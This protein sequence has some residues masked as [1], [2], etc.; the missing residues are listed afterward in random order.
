MAPAFDSAFR[1]DALNLIMAVVLGGA[2][3]FER[4]WR[5]RLAGLRTNTLVSLGAAIFVVFEGQ[6]TDT[7]QLGSPRRSSR[8]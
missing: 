8:A 2:I 6:F 4:Q 5:Q 3:G 7:V 1:N